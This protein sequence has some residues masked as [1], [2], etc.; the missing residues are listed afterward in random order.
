MQGTKCT[1]GTANRV[2][3]KPQK[4]AGA[5]LKTHSENTNY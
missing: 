2:V 3:S 5:N 4:E 1:F